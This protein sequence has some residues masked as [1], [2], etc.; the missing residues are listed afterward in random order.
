MYGIIFDSD[1]I[2]R[3]KMGSICKILMGAMGIQLISWIILVAV[4]GGT[5]IMMI[6]DPILLDIMECLILLIPGTIYLE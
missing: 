5:I 3:R 4:N 1:V 2:D 6:Q